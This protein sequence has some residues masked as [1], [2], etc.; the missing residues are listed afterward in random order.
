MYG[1]GES[2]TEE[3]ITTRLSYNKYKCAKH[4]SLCLTQY[5]S[6]ECNIHT[7]LRSMC[8]PETLAFL[9]V[10]RHFFYRDVIGDSQDRFSV[11][12]SDTKVN[13]RVIFSARSTTICCAINAVVATTEIE[14]FDLIRKHDIAVRT[15]SIHVHIYGVHVE[16]CSSMQL[17]S[18]WNMALWRALVATYS[19]RW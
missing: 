1:R 7:A 16:L 5:K 18:G 4:R 3:W 9:P 19:T 11:E 8:Q 15:L 12:H 6:Y 17:Q 10:C 13:G 2:N 14:S